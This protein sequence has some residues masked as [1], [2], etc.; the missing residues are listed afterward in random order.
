MYLERRIG[1]R[2]ARDVTCYSTFKINYET[3]KSL[4]TLNKVASQKKT[5]SILKLLDKLLKIKPLSTLNKVASQKKTLINIEREYVFICIY[6]EP[7]RKLFPLSCVYG[8]YC[9]MIL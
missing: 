3:N 5:I 2:G 4:S 8:I 6:A 9:G 1:A 7:Q